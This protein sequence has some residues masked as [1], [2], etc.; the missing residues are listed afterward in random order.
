VLLPISLSPWLVAPGA[1]AFAK[2][3]YPL[4]LTGDQHYHTIALV[5]SD[6]KPP[7]HGTDPSVRYGPLVL[8]GELVHKCR[9]DLC[10]RYNR[11]GVL[12]QKPL[13][14]GYDM[15]LRTAIAIDHETRLEV[16][17]GA[18]YEIG[19]LCTRRH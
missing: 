6:A 14:D 11:V 18:P 2:H 9:R 13:E 17:R 1:I 12:A 16:M 5:K 7:E 15:T 4:V 3:R 19:K 10:D 8:T